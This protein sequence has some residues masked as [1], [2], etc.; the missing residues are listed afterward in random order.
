MPWLLLILLLSSAYAGCAVGSA[1]SGSELSPR[2]GG[3]VRILAGLQRDRLLESAVAAPLTPGFLAVA[4]T[5]PRAADS[6]DPARVGCWSFTLEPRASFP[7][8]RPV[9]AEDLVS[10]WETGLREPSSAHHWLLG[11]VEGSAAF[12]RGAA[13]AVSGLRAVDGRLEICVSAAAPDLPE[14]L[15][16]P[17][18]WLR[19]RGPSEGRWEGPGPFRQT[20]VDRLG[21][22]PFGAVAPYL[23]K[24]HFVDQ[25]ETDPAL[26]LNL[27]QA[28]LGVVF[29]RAAARLQRDSLR[30]LSQSRLPRW[31][32][33]YFLWI[34]RQARWVNDPRFRRW[35]S[36]AIDRQSMV[37][38]LFSGEG[39]PAY[40]LSGSVA[41]N[42]E[43]GPRPL[44]AASRPRLSLAFDEDD[45]FAV[46]IAE[47]LV[48]TLRLEGIDL[49]L[50]PRGAIELR[51]ADAGSPPSAILSVHQ[52]ASD[53][54][55]LG[56][57]ESVWRLAGPESDT[58]KQLERASR[59]ADPGNRVE[60]AAQIE[61]WVLDQG[62]LIPLLRLHAWL[63][64]DARL[65]DV[66]TGPPGVLR[67]E[68]SWWLP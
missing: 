41:T 25:S 48:A 27:A 66:E 23:D 22:N 37:D 32:R 16:H 14:R 38:Y 15:A 3:E 46:R 67:L 36:D 42:R 54:P 34:D 10:S 17:A 11:P 58:I 65:R 26:L 28:D 18:L 51:R 52:P 47:R 31:D 29:G 40:T 7:D 33:T 44:G 50:A 13:A 35:L 68:R 49:S 21:A 20:G 56:M 2:R 5:A 9:S 1:T 19:R 4:S 55:V 43:T 12:G 57:T 24:A 61:R 63:V 64:V 62:R 45:P 6:S 59:I 8:G 30:E 39:E 60:A 53:D